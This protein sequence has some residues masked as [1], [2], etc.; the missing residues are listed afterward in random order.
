MKNE[1]R[2][3]RINSEVAATASSS[4]IGAYGTP[5]TQTRS[6]VAVSSIR[7]LRR[8]SPSLA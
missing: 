5:Q 8:E 1:G 7:P 2:P 4:V 3:A 6:H